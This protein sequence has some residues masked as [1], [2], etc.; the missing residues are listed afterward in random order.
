MAPIFVRLKFRKNTGRPNSRKMLKYLKY[1]PAINGKVLLPGVIITQ[2]TDDL[3]ATQD[4]IVSEYKTA[5]FHQLISMLGGSGKLMTAFGV[6]ATVAQMLGIQLVSELSSEIKKFSRHE[7]EVF[8]NRK[9]LSGPFSQ[10]TLTALMTLTHRHPIP[11]SD[12]IAGLLNNADIGLRTKPSGQG[13][14]GLLSKTK[15]GAQLKD[16]GHMEGVTRMRL[17]RAFVYNEIGVY[18]EQLAK[19]QNCIQQAHIN[20]RIRMEAAECEGKFCLTDLYIYVLDDKLDTV[21]RVIPI[22]D[23][24]EMEFQNAQ[25]LVVTVKGDSQPLIMYCPDETSMMKLHHFIRSQSIMFDIFKES[26]I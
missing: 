1:V 8:D 11:K 18:D 10:E 21:R 24:T 7:S 13:V 16:V 25:N 4:K 23:V 3:K 2:I 6:T 26:I 20:E 19:A 12:F 14:I 5:A 9:E 22:T 17:P 15:S